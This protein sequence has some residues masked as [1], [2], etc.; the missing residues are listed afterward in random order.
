M[1][2]TTVAALWDAY[3]AAYRVNDARRIMEVSQEIR[4]RNAVEMAGHRAI[5]R[6]SEAALSRKEQP[7]NLMSCLFGDGTGTVPSCEQVKHVLAGGNF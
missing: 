1:N 2:V 5:D 6:A 4:R 3:R 7:I